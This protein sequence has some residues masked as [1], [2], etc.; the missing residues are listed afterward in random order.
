MTPDDLEP[1]F[2]EASGLRINDSLSIPRSELSTKASRS[3]GAGGQHVNKT[4]SRIEIAWNISES[5]ALSD[6]QRERLLTRLASRLSDDGSIRVVA[7]DTRSQ[8]RNREAAEA[9]LA[10]TIARAL[11]VPRK[12]R[13]TRRPRAANEARLVEKKKHSDKKRERQRRPAE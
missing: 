8:L 13:P 1:G 7:S 9:R 12:R 2:S 10:E 4:S 3:S 6:E 11:I 5:R